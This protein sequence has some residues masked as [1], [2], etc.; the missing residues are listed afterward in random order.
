MDFGT[1]SGNPLSCCFNCIKVA[2][3][4]ISVYFSMAS[5]RS[6]INHFER[7]VP[8]N[9]RR[10]G[11]PPIPLSRLYTCHILC[12][13]FLLKRKKKKKS[14]NVFL[15]VTN[16]LP[17][18]S[19]FYRASSLLVWCLLLR[20]SSSPSVVFG[21][22]KYPSTWL[23]SLRLLPSLS[24][25]SRHRTINFPPLAVR[26]RKIAPMSLPLPTS[27][28]LW[29]SDKVKGGQT[30]VAACQHSLE[31][32]WLCGRP[33]GQRGTFPTPESNFMSVKRAERD[34]RS[35]AVSSHVA[36]FTARLLILWDIKE[37]TTF[38]T[39]SCTTVI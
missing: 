22:L 10:G 12:F 11:K 5:W 29:C 36:L 31:T 33:W 18:T 21:T 4:C 32:V 17:H 6:C 37:K 25:W 20:L 1:R 23:L 2:G 3:V 30:V 13:F 15:G 35:P 38:E 26:G 9:H 28:L 7:I 14:S 24:A 8:P 34:Q 19:P 39:E 16:N 27:C